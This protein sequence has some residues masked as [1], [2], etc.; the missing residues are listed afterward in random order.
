[1]T[2]DDLLDELAVI[3]LRFSKQIDETLGRLAA[4][5]EEHP[6]AEPEEAERTAEAREAL[7]LVDAEIRA[8]SAVLTEVLP[9]LVQKTLRI[10][11]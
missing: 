4:W 7:R 2:E 5:I 11:G 6:D 3:R 8:V 9:A 10:R 1:M